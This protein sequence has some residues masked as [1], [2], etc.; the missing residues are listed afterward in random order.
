MS[1][2]NCLQVS[3]FGLIFIAHKSGV[4][5]CVFIRKAFLSTQKN[6]PQSDTPGAGFDARQADYH[7]R[8]IG[9]F[10][11]KVMDSSSETFSPSMDSE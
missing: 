6:E 1:I 9:D 5:H 7:M 3:E 8:D 11:S 10:S 2:H 4:L